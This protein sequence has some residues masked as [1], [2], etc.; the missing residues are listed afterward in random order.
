MRKLVLVVAVVVAAI[1]YLGVEPTSGAFN[2]KVTN[3]NNTVTS[4]AH[5]CTAVALADNPT[6]FYELNETTGTVAYD[7]SPTAANGTYQGGRQVQDAVEYPCLRETQPYAVL[8][9]THYVSTTGT[10]TLS[11]STSSSHEAWFRTHDDLGGV[12][13]GIGDL[14][15][16]ASTKKDNMILLTSNGTIAFVTNNPSPYEIVTPFAYND[17]AWHHVVGVHDATYG[18]RLYLDG[19]L[20]VQLAGAHPQSMTGYMR[21]GYDNTSGYANGFGSNQTTAHF[22]GNLAFMAYYPYALSAARIS[23]HYAAGGQ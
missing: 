1:A 21:I 2:A 10:I 18:I 7:G 17:G 15:T 20:I 23:A 6:R 9:N 13:S 12:I 5:T 22:R 8:D 16:G 14:A 11:A 3:S 4:L 19:Q